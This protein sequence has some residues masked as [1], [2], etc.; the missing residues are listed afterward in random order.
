[1]RTSCVFE[2]WGLLAAVPVGVFS[3]AFGIVSFGSLAQ[4]ASQQSASKVVRVRQDD[5]AKAA[6][7]RRYRGIQNR[8]G[9]KQ[10]TGKEGSFEAKMDARAGPRH[11]CPAQIE[12]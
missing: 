6:A 5:A 7:A 4:P 11:L 3:I 9:P 8:I 10:R 1:M 2:R 12:A